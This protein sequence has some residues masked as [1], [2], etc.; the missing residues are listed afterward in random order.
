MRL[1]FILLLLGRASAADLPLIS[2][3]F[4]DHM[5]LQRD[6]PNVLWGWTQPGTRVSVEIAGKR[7]EGTASGD[8]RWQV[9]IDPPATGGPYTVKIEGPQ[10]LE[11]KDVLVG[12]VWLCG[13]QSN[14]VWGLADARDGTAEVSRSAN[15]SLRLF[16]VAQ[17]PAYHPTTSVAGTWRTCEPASFG[18]DGGFSAVAYYFGRKIQAETGVPVGLI[19]SAVGGSPAEAWMSPEALSAFPEFKPELAEMA[20][21]AATGGKVYGSFVMHWFEQYDRGQKE[22]WSR[23]DFDD[24]AWKT[25]T[26]HDGFA[27][28]GV[29]AT[30][31]VVWF[32]RDVE[33]PDPLPPGEVKIKLGVVEKMDTV[34]LNE[35]WIGASSWVENARTYTIPAGTLRPGKNRLAF[36]VLKTAPDGGFRTPASEQ[37]I[38]WA[39]GTDV[40]LA[41]DWRV[42]LGAD[43]RPPHPLPL[44][45]EN[46]PTMPASLSLGMIQPLAPL[47]VKGALW[48]QGEANTTRAAQYR[49]L[50]P[51]LIADWRAQFQQPALPFHIVQLPAFMKRRE[52]PGTD[53]WAELRDAQALAARTVPNTG[54]AVT[55]DTGDADDIHPR[56]KQPVGERLALVAL[57]KTYGRDIASEGPVFESASR[58]KDSL[59]L[60]FRCAKGGLVEK[61]GAPPE[62]DIAGADKVWHRAT[63]RID[64]DVVV[65]SS[66]AVPSPLAARYAWQANPAATLTDATGLPAAP[67][68]TDAR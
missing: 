52:T 38:K 23:E 62:F 50:L 10:T 40:P 18:M 47:A 48:Y 6:R 56:D 59:R 44:G 42:A 57:R 32:R 8:G 51:A 58:E 46:Y 12:D 30:P 65:V 22:N 14:M 15:P 20:K 11:L 24:S 2:P 60:R 13:G 39:G 55:I 66:P 35:K 33:L 41:G 3:L 4:G 29:A 25:S 27:A 67:F 68:R 37:K 17:A 7:A 61:N 49:K 1:F 45:Y 19:Q 5:V 43:A 26:L 9:S 63:A 53:G 21:L 34:Y 54:L 64:G 36:R 28:L 31:A 16:R